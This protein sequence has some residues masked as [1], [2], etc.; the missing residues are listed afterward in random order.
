LLFQ[1][2]P[3]EAPWFWRSNFSPALRKKATRLL[4][5][6]RAGGCMEKRIAN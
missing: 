3:D 5:V 6:S 2:Q 1:R 4:S